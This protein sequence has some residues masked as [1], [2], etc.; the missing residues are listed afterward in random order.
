[1]LIVNFK[2]IYFKLLI[3]MNKSIFCLLVW[4]LFMI[5]CEKNNWFYCNLNFVN[6]IYWGIVFIYRLSKV[7][8]FEA[9][10]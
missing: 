4:T 8:I 1:M 2:I 7:G 5:D 10:V 3:V 9:E 6:K